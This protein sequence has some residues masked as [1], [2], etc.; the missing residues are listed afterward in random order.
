MTL[1][2]QYTKPNITVMTLGL[3][4]LYQAEASQKNVLDNKNGEKASH[5]HADLENV[6]MSSNPVSTQTI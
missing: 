6:P 3:I 5:N 2:Y 4:R 1:R